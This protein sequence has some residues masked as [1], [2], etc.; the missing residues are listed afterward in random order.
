MASL[1]ADAAAAAAAA[2]TT[3]T[4][5]TTAA[6]TI[7]GG[8][9]EDGILCL[10]ERPR[11][12]AEGDA[13]EG[14][15]T[16]LRLGSISPDYGGHDD[17][18]QSASS[19]S[20]VV[21]DWEL[22]GS[23]SYD[24]DALPPH[25]DLAADAVDPILDAA[26]S[27][28]N[29]SSLDSSAASV[30]DDASVTSRASRIAL[31][32]ALRID[33]NTLEAEAEAIQPMEAT[34][35]D[36]LQQ[37]R[38]RFVMVNYIF[39]MYLM[40]FHGLSNTIA[41]LYLSFVLHVL[42]RFCA[43]AIDAGTSA[44]T[45]GPPP[46]PLQPSPPPPPQRLPQPLQTSVS[47]QIEHE[48]MSQPSA[49]STRSMLA[50]ASGD[51]QARS[52]LSLPPPPLSMLVTP[53]S[54]RSKLGLHSDFVQYLVCP[55]CGELKLWSDTEGSSSQQIFCACGTEL[56]GDTGRR[57]VQLY[58]H[59]TLESIFS[60]VLMDSRYYNALYDWTP[61][62]DS[63][64]AASSTSTARYA[65]IS[66][67]SAWL[68]DCGDGASAC[69]YRCQLGHAPFVAT[70]L[71]LKVT[72]SVDWFGPHKGKF[73]EWHS[74][75][76]VLLRIDN[77]PARLTTY[78]RR[79]LG[80]HLVGLLPGPKDTTAQNLQKFLKL[81]VEELKDFDGDGKLIPT[82]NH[83]EGEH[84]Q[85]RLHLVVADTP[86]RA[87]V[88]GFALKYKK[89]TICA[90][91]PKQ[92]EQ[93]G[94]TDDEEEDDSFVGSQ[95]R[96]PP[97]TAARFHSVAIDRLTY[98]N[99]VDSCPPDVM[100]AVHLGLCKRFW[101]RFLIESCNEIGKRLPEAQHI[102][103]SALLPSI[104]QGPNRRIG[105]KSG[106]N[107]TAEQ[108]EV[109]FR[110]LL[111]FV[112]MQLWSTSLCGDYDEELTF[113]VVKP[114]GPR[115]GVPPARSSGRDFADAAALR[116][117]L[118]PPSNAA[119]L[120]DA[121]DIDDAASD[122]DAE[123]EEGGARRGGARRG[124]RQLLPGPKAVRS[125]FRSAMLLCSIV[126]LV[127]GDLTDSDVDK[128]AD[129]ITKYNRSQ[130]K[131]LGPAWLTFNNHN[132][133]HLPYF[134]RRFGSPRH[135][136]SLPFERY[137][138]IMG[139]IPTSGH[140]GGV[141]EAT[142][143]RNAAQRNE[144]RRLLAQSSE[145]FMKT[146][147]LGEIEGPEPT[148]LPS[149]DTRLKK[150][151]LDN[152]S[153]GLLLAHLNGRAEQALP[154]TTIASSPPRY[155]PSWDTTSPSTVA[156]LDTTAEFT[157]TAT[158]AR[159]PNKVKVGG[160]G[161][162]G[163]D[164]RANCWCLVSVDG[165]VQAAKILWIF[166]KAVRLSRTTLNTVPQTF[167]HVRLLEE[168]S[169]DVLGGRHPSLD[170]IAGMGMRLTLDNGGEYGEE[171]LVDFDCYQSQLAVVPFTANGHRLLGLKSLGACG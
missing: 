91:C 152:A 36:P 31:A 63:N 161:Q 86:A 166:T 96:G 8:S 132:V 147:L 123:A 140:K 170:L 115:S 100:H 68:E 26:R 129:Y 160:V 25:P 138:G 83:P 102:I 24:S 1:A 106:G 38:S 40:T 169:L 108:W 156:R 76:A 19:P 122:G 128:L 16:R 5:A 52:S 127:S 148:S 103:A 55:R 168:V 150:R 153:F 59:R 93:L 87:K 73:H 49:V 7:S 61:T 95:R 154:S 125:V 27:N 137:N 99:A 155:T 9:H 105:S 6:G 135:F 139:T 60:G 4:T 3:A 71:N 46:P 118:P 37:Q 121:I 167:M 10:A 35:T 41:T 113:A 134:T 17:H 90:Y 57:P 23:D 54:V 104:I 119:L 110:V 13:G 29:S 34:L 133:S 58:C 107:P 64:T 30:E 42:S 81:I 92:G 101:H 80:I 21:P 12:E 75:G 51:T 136:S 84:V 146:R 82:L 163:R 159:T 77:L 50:S 157:R 39:V 85:A 43:F 94:L 165:K 22:D 65:E 78:D 2:A 62:A 28:A 126:E 158:M 15:R 142:I 120:A 14:R 33:A 109:L 145:P 98:F 44:A 56:L 131:L 20:D 97:R 89:G 88:A 171:L 143:M 79:C 124:G 117:R 70:G 151:K 48:L 72:L 67:G 53:A 74:T 47:S 144:L 149:L 141:L 111:P 116:H 69:Q 114:G 18:A 45:T 66:S 130:A 32:R 162:G 112:L 164:N 11:R